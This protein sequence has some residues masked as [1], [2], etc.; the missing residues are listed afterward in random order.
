MKALVTGSTG[1]VGANLVEALNARGVEVV[2]LQRQNSPQIG[3]KGLN[4]RPVIGDILNLDSL[5][6]AVEGVDW[7]FHVA[8]IA[9]DWNHPADKVYRVNV[10]GTR[11]VLQA[12]L[13]A[14]VSRVVYTSSSS[15]LGMPEEDGELLDETHAFNLKPTDW[16]YGHSK[17]LAMEVV[18]SFVEKGLPAVTVLPTAIMGPKDLK[19][20]SGQLLVR[21]LK[22]EILPFPEGGVNFIDMRDV[23]V[24][25]ISAAEKGRVGERYLLAAHNMAHTE[26][27]AIISRVIGVAART[28]RLPRWSLPLLADVVTLLRRLGLQLPIE[29]GRVLMSGK[30]IYYDNSKAV[31]ELGLTVRPFAETVYDSYQWYVENG[32]FQKRGITAQ[33]LPPRAN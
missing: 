16:A 7:V 1:G 11:N 31:Q 19:F 15:A 24:G 29:R 2:G 14:R 18:D 17:W 13:D 4:V 26:T 6:P 32:C 8:A 21:V 9:D 3:L 27:A 28:I 33:P 25:H 20:I 30:Y 10:E 23:A 22:R 5:R 12:A